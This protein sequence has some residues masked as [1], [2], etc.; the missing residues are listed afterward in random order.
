[1]KSIENISV[2]YSRILLYFG[3]C[4]YKGDNHTEEGIE[5]LEEEVSEEID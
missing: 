1:M 4:K 5:E 3:T 2:L